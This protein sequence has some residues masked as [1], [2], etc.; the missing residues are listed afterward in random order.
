MSRSFPATALVVCGR[1]LSPL[2]LSLSI[3]SVKECCWNKADEAESLP[4]CRVLK[5]P[6]SSIQAPTASLSR[7]PPSALPMRQLLSQDPCL[8]RSVQDISHLSNLDSKTTLFLTISSHKTVT[9]PLSFLCLT[10]F[11]DELN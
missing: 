1:L 2:Q 3:Y 11:L 6:P 4:S 10:V 9:F 7:F 5:E 8:V